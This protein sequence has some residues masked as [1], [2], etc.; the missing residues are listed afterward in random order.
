MV[1]PKKSQSQPPPEGL[2]ESSHETGTIFQA[3]TVLAGP[4]TKSL[5]AA[6]AGSVGS[7]WPVHVVYKTNVCQDSQIPKGGLAPTA[8]DLA[9]TIVLD[10]Y[11]TQCPKLCH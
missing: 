6:V 11:P 4:T 8:V 10:A 3:V 2:N 9:A 7:Q 1:C 5:N